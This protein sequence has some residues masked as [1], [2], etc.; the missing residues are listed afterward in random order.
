VTSVVQCPASPAWPTGGDLLTH[1]QYVQLAPRP[2]TDFTPPPDTTP[3]HPAIKGDLAAAFMA[4]PG[5]SKNELCALDGILINRVGCINPGN[6]TDYDPSNC[7]GMA[8]ADIAANSWGLRTPLNKKYISISLGLWR[9]Q[10]GRGYCAP[11]FT[12]FHQLLN[13]ALLDKTACKDQNPPCKPA[14]INPPTSQPSA[15]VSGLSVLAVLAHERG[16]IY[17]WEIFVKQPHTTPQ[18]A[19][20]INDAATFCN[21]AI[22]PGGRWQGM[23]VGL[24]NNRYVEFADLNPN[25]AVASLPALLRSGDPADARR[26]SAVIDRIYAGGRYPSLLAAYSSDEDFVEAFEWSVLRNAGLSDLTVNGHPVL[27]GGHA[28][29]GA[30]PKLRCFDALSH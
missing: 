11:S 18:P 24:P 10:S 28:G 12:Q 22:Y 7:S 21:G 4:N 30:E 19:T 15:D 2:D 14:N 1:F 3:I 26:A 29:M 27:Q 25:S 5:F 9:C 6:P 23:A 13:K 8:D 17:W 16:H 20:L